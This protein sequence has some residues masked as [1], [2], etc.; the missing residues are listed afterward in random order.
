MERSESPTQKEVYKL[1]RMSDKELDD[2]LKSGRICRMALN[3]SPQPYIIPLDYVYI[4]GRV[5]FHFADYG[6][7]VDLYRKNPNVS[8]EVD[9]YNDDVTDYR[10][11]TLMGRLV[12]VTD[13]DEKGLVADALLNS[14]KAREDTGNVAARHG[15]SSLDR[16]TLMSG[17]SLLLRL[18]V[19]DYVA[20]KSPDM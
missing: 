4:N 7:K 15:F 2:L 5:Y 20:L 19:T 8:I 11:A 18:D 17:D 14:I 10:N 16:D 13:P 1:P 6:H 12:K 3:D 9:Q